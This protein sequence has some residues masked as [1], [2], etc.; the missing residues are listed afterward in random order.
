MEYEKIVKI[1]HEI[2]G[3]NKEEIT[4]RSSFYDDLGAD[5]LD[6]YQIV[7]ALEDA[8]DLDIPSVDIERIDTVEDAIRAVRA[9]RNQG[10]KG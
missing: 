8:F 10:V 1:I 5:S 4:L 6:V 3:V 9:A 7:T 2:I